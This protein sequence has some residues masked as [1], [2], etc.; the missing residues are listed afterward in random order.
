MKRD[1]GFTHPLYYKH[2][3]QDKKVRQVESRKHKKMYAYEN[4][5]RNKSF[6]RSTRE[7]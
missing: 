6:V 3:E 7:H 4:Y 5:M 2:H 1:I